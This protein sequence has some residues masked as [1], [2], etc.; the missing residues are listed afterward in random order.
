MDKF[1]IDNRYMLNYIRLSIEARQFCE[2]RDME[3]TTINNLFALMEE[4][5]MKGVYFKLKELNVDQCRINWKDF[6]DV[7][8]FEIM[9]PDLFK[10]KKVHVLSS[11]DNAAT[12]I[13]GQMS[14]FNR[15]FYYKKDN[16]QF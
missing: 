5:E 2:A 13:A 9:N 15:M 11:N 12:M 3:M 8:N 16:T 7:K 4:Q 10:G 6:Q 1:S 14:A